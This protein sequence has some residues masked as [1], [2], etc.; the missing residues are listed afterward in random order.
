MRSINTKL[1]R[2]ILAS[3]IITALIITSSFIIFSRRAIRTEAFN[4]LNEEVENIE[5]LFKNGE[6]LDNIRNLLDLR[7]VILRKPFIVNRLL[8]ISEKKK[9]V[10]FLVNEEI[11]TLN[12]KIVG[13]ISDDLKDT[14]EYITFVMDGIENIGVAY[15][16]EIATR[17]TALQEQIKIGWIY[18]YVPVEEIGL[19]KGILRI[20]F[21][22]VVFSLLIGAGISIY[23]SRKITKPLKQ[24]TIYSKKISDRKFNEIEHINTGD[25]FEELSDEFVKMSAKLKSYDDKQKEFFQNASHNLKTPLMSIKGYAE[26]ILDNVTVDKEK[27]L[28]VIIDESDRLS[29]LVK[30]ILF[31]SKSGSV[32]EFYNFEKCSLEDILKEVYG[33]VSAITNESGVSLNLDIE[34]DHSIMADKEKLIDG[35][36]NVLSNAVRYARTAIRIKTEKMG[37]YVLISIEDDGEGIEEGEE[38]KVFERF[39]QGKKGNYGLGLSITKM[40]IEKHGGKIKTRNINKGAR[41]EILLKRSLHVSTEI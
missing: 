28:N 38:E 18:L 26:A 8:L 24:L 30:K 9:N 13:K 19:N 5:S 31:I 12:N 10:R 36:M 3:I 35:I 7:Q 20:F 34:E 17:T 15:K 40:I 41:F 32:E 11:N 23:Y 16:V 2:V 37:E 22:S 6:T 33:K 39:Y 25:E 29:E 27:A 1:I 21:I 4:R 14:K